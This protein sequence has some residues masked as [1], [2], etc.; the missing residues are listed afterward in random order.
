MSGK[1]MWTGASGLADDVRY[2]GQWMRDRAFE[3]IGHLYPKVKM[4]NG[5]EATVIAWLWARTV[6][7]PNPACGARMPLVRSFALSTKS[8]KKAWVEPVIDHTAKS[9]R[10]K[11]KTGDGIAPEGIVSRRGARCLVCGNTASLDEVRKE[12]REGEYGFLGVQ[13]ANLSAAEVLAGAGLRGARVERVVVAYM[14]RQIPNTSELR[15]RLN[16]C[17]LQRPIYQR[18]HS[19]WAHRDMVSRNTLTFSLEGN[20][21]L[22]ER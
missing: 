6:L 10:F 1:G 18:T 21:W 20:S 11:V 7:C 3:R 22:W 4:P 15:N 2:Y 17:G 16:L 19:T 9:V 5:D 13:P 8:G 14:S 12:G